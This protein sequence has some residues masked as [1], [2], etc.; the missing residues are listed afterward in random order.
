MRVDPC[1][2]AECKGCGNVRRPKIAVRGVQCDGTARGMGNCKVSADR[3]VD[4]K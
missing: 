4:S 1:L 2:C 3:V